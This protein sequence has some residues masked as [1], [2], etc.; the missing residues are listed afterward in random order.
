MIETQEVSP[1]T[2]LAAAGES[3]RTETGETGA[4]HLSVTVT[5]PVFENLC[6]D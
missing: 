5:S 6:V 3:A 1:R 4:I 2:Q